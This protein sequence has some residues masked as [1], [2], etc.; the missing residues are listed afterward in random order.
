MI[1]KMIKAGLFEEEIDIYFGLK[2]KEERC[3]VY[4]DH[5]GLDSAMG[6]ASWS[7]KRHFSSSYRCIKDMYKLVSKLN[8]PYD[9]QTTIVDVGCGYGR[10]GLFIGIETYH[11]NYVGVEI[12]PERVEEA[13]RIKASLIEKYSN[14]AN[15]KYEVADL[16]AVACPEGSVY[17]MYD[18]LNEGTLKKVLVEIASKPGRYIYF[19]PARASTT[20]IVTGFQKLFRITEYLYL[21]I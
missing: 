19:I 15:V 1:A 3:G 14:F 2:M 21:T 7:T 13:N 18:P 4:E 9:G 6:K 17:Y 20:R 8:F 5:M 10:L 11:F 12:N 16:S